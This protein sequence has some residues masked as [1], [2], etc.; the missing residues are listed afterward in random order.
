MRSEDLHNED[1]EV[2]H[3]YKQVLHQATL[4]APLEARE[5][6][7]LS[8]METILL[9]MGMIPGFLFQLP[10]ID[11]GAVTKLAHDIYLEGIPFAKPH[12]RIS[13]LYASYYFGTE[14]M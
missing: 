9:Q 11:S 8:T 13:R 5:F 10:R 2:L 7:S 14:A 12:N 6:H 1:C 3:G 4:G